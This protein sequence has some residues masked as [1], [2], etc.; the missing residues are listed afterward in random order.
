MS[1]REAIGGCRK[2]ITDDQWCIV[3]LVFLWGGRGLLTGP[4]KSNLSS[5][6]Y[7]SELNR[8]FF[9]KRQQELEET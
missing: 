3:F 4:C 9:T 7:V 6:G 2:K 1:F 8:P 5:E